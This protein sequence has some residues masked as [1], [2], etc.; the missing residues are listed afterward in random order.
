MGRSTAAGIKAS[1]PSGACSYALSTLDAYDE[2]QKITDS[3]YDMLEQGISE[4]AA[5]HNL[6]L[7]P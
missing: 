3:Q 6:P 4:L 1:N 5:S 2:L 7:N